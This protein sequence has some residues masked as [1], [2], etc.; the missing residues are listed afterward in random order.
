MAEETREKIR[1]SVT[2]NDPKFYGAVTYQPDDHGTSH[3]SVLDGDG[4]AVSI[5]STVNL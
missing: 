4:M 2:S 5:T 1:N 3:M